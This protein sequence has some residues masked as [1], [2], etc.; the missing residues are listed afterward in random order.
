MRDLGTLDQF[1]RS[2][3]VSDL[4]HYNLLNED[5]VAWING[6]WRLSRD[7]YRR[8]LH[9]IVFELNNIHCQGKTYAV[10]ENNVWR[11]KI[12]DAKICIYRRSALRG[13]LI[14][15][16][17]PQYSN[18]PVNVQHDI[19]D[20]RRVIINCCIIGELKM[21]L[22]PDEEEIIGV[23]SGV[24]FDPNFH[25]ER[26]INHFFFFSKLA[27][28]HFMCALSSL[29]KDANQFDLCNR[30]EKR[31]REVFTKFWDTKEDPKT[32]ERIPVFT[33]EEIDVLG[34]LGDGK[35]LVSLVVLFGNKVEHA[36]DDTKHI[37]GDSY[38][39]IYDFFIRHFPRL[40]VVC[41]S[42]LTDE[43]WQDELLNVHK[44]YNSTYR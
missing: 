21:E 24:L 28:V 40:P 36:R 4:L 22:M 14:K 39:K 8:I 38:E 5:E 2:E 6:S 3:F 20:L 10:G 31:K 13:R 41:A 19:I 44:H 35:S 27:W 26:V 37:I 34:N 32:R 9:D 23:L 1:F 42:T 11:Q 25:I 16:C 33:D 15:L 17:P 18:D 30:L 7:V 29:V 12:D 43:D